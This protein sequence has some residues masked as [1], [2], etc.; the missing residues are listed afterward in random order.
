MTTATL[1]GIWGS[2]KD[3]IWAVGQGGTALYFN[4]SSWKN[5]NTGI[6]GSPSL[7]DVWGVG[8]DHLYAVGANSLVLRFK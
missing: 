8:T 1:T 4:G 7:Y 6:Q 3:Q 2:A 5:R